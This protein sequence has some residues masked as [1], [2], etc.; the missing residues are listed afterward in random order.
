[1]VG[2]VGRIEPAKGTLDL[3]KAAPA[4]LRSRPGAR[5]VIVGDGGESPRYTSLVRRRVAALGGVLLAG[6]TP[7]ARALMGWFDV[8]AVPS[9][10]EAFGSVAAEALAAGTPVVAS[11]VG[12]IREY[13]R[14]S[15][16]GAL[17]PPGD[18]PA[19]A[20]ALKASLDASAAGRDRTAEARAA[21]ER[22][23]GERV[24]DAVAAAFTEALDSPGAGEA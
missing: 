2:Y 20:A 16:A 13:L 14:G 12:G 17:V 5:I 22:F 10:T 3:L 8:L 15:P 9:R 24:A 11:D 23:S 7:D 4:V 18:P 6:P 19:L 21:V 1:V